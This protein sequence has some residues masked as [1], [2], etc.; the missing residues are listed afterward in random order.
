MIVSTARLLCDQS[1]LRAEPGLPHADVVGCGGLGSAM[2]R[3]SP[4][5]ELRALSGLFGHIRAPIF[6]FGWWA[7]AYRTA[8]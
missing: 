3:L 7:R 4:C 1:V 2:S 5:N 6:E 8:E